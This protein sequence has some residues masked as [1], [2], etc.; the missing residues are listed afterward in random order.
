MTDSVEGSGQR[1]DSTLFKG[2]MILET[3]AASATPMSVTAIARQLELT[4]SSAYR[5]LQ[6]LCKLGYVR[7]GEDKLYG[8]TFKMW[9]VGRQVVTHLNLRELAVTQMGRLSQLTGHTVYLAVPEGLSVLYIDKVE[10]RQPIRSWN[11]VGGLAP[12]HAVST[13]RAII[14]ADYPRWRDRLKG[15]LTRYTPLTLTNI[16]ELDEEVER[17][18]A[19]G[20]AE[21]RG[22]FRDRVLGFGAA[23]LLPHGKPVGAIGINM[24]DINLDEAKRDLYQQLV[25]EAA[26]EITASLAAF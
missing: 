9:R 8:A 15:N 16:R 23:I 14:A 13:G 24:P 6:T 19:Q 3:L 4:K 2:L 7:Q 10:S 20:F 1:V 21:D 22:E 11:P 12:I 26:E 25:R 18:R 17:I 5:L